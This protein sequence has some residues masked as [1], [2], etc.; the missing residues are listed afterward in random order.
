MNK[1]FENNSGRIHYTDIGEGQVV[2]LIHGYLETSEVLSS[3]TNKLSEKFRVIAVD[4]PG[5]GKSE[6]TEKVLTMELMASVIAKLVQNLNIKK[7]FLTG[8]SLGGYV[9]LAFVD[10]YPELL[11]GYCLLHSHP[12]SD[13]KGKVEKRN[14]EI[15]IVEKGK[16]DWFIPENIS[17]LYATSNIRKFGEA[18]KHSTEVALKVPDETIVAVLKG[19]ILRSSRVTVMESGKVPLLWILGAS[20]NLINCE[21]VQSKVK[22]PA[23]AEIVVLKNSGHMGFIE[24]EER[25]VEI[26]YEYVNKI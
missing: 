4:L 1:F 10:M 7:I 15:G 14:I 3:F 5:H 8:H 11:S 16:K 25:S 19:M 6:N 17:K 26:I 13:D 23:N 2:V 21:E 22:M 9:T 20:D 24:E 12:F 18:L